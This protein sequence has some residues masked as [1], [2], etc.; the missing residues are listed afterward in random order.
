M[1]D[2]NITIETEPQLNTQETRALLAAAGDDVF[3]RDM[4]ST[5]VQGEADVEGAPGN[6]D[7]TLTRRD[8]GKLEGMQTELDTFLRFA[9]EERDEKLTNLDVMQVPSD[10]EIA[11]AMEGGA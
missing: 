4:V 10:E 6:V 7:V 9:M 5:S 1:S 3:H 8:G 2:L 11:K